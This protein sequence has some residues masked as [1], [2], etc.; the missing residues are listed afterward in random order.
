[1]TPPFLRGNKTGKNI[2]AVNDE[3]SDV[4][5]GGCVF[6]SDM[7]MVDWTGTAKRAGFL[8]NPPRLFFFFFFSGQTSSGYGWRSR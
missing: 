2:Y 4:N 3:I 5:R 1:M 8:R 7:I 6:P